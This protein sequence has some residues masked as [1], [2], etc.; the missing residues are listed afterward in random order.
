MVEQF[1]FQLLNKAYAAVVGA[2][3]TMHT[4]LIAENAVTT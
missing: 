4:P 1:R 3:N 2:Q